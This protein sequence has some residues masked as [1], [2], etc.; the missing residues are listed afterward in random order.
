MSLAHRRCRIFREPCFVNGLAVDHLNALYGR[1]AV[2]GKGGSYYRVGAA[3]SAAGRLLS[4][5]LPGR[6]GSNLS[7]C[8]GFGRLL[9]AGRTFET[10]RRAFSGSSW[11]ESVSTTTASRSSVGGS[12]VPWKATAGPV[13]GADELRPG[14]G[15]A[16]QIVGDYRKLHKASPTRF[17]ASLNI[18]SIL[19]GR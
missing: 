18:A 11:R 16:G 6:A 5:L 9:V 19:Y 15:R 2:A 4:L 8:R 10:R 7:F 13:S 12:S 3:H 14:I 1:P 17:G